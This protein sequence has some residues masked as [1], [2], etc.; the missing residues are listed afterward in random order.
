[1]PRGAA[2][3][4]CRQQATA[5]KNKTGETQIENV[6]E[7][8][9]SFRT[10]KRAVSTTTFSPRESD[11]AL[12]GIKPNAK[13]YAWETSERAQLLEIDARNPEL[14]KAQHQLLDC[15][16][17]LGS[18]L[19]AN[20]LPIAPPRIPASGPAGEAPPAKAVLHSCLHA[21]FQSSA[22]IPL[23]EPI[24]R[25]AHIFFLSLQPRRTKPGWQPE[26]KGAR[27]VLL[28]WPEGSRRLPQ[29]QAT[30]ALSFRPSFKL[31][32][33]KGSLR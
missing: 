17:L 13:V 15:V 20:L 27:R 10:S 33:C 26:I 4:K 1:M 9:S 19:F 12:A 11:M 8:E 5:A 31:F 6:A 14:S 21:R 16:P 23:A 22:R 29:V 30:K 24:S 7:I 32:T 28:R 3:K 18:H 25:A 2:P